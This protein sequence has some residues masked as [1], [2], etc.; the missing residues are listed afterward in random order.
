VI[1]ARDGDVAGF[2]RLAQRIQHLAGEFRHLVEE[3][4]AVMRQ[5]NFAR[6]RAQ[7]AADQL[8]CRVYPRGCTESR[9]GRGHLVDGWEDARWYSDR[10]RMPVPCYSVNDKLHWDWVLFGYRNSWDF[11]FGGSQNRTKDRCCCSGVRRICLQA[12]GAVSGRK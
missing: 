3:Q 7:A 1:D 9:R 6:P 2:Q 10:C 4:H 8:C 12:W 5:R 11:L